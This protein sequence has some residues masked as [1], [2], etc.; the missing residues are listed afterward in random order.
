MYKSTLG[1]KVYKRYYDYHKFTTLQGLFNKF[2]DFCS[3]SFKHVP[4]E[5]WKDIKVFVS[6]KIQAIRYKL[7]VR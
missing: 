2:I 7:L 3:H 4:L 5:F 1:E 6:S